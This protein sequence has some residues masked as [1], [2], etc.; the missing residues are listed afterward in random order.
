MDGWMGFGGGL[1]K[2]KDKDIAGRSKRVARPKIMHLSESFS[3][4]AQ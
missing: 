4:L 2:D 1:D 3:S